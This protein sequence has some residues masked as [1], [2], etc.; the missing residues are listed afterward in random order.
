MV[1]ID[2][3]LIAQIVKEVLAGMPQQEAAA[4]PAEGAEEH[5]Y[6]AE[7][8]PLY[9]KHPDNIRS[10]TGKKLSEIT[11]QAVVDGKIEAA[12]VRISPDTLA[13]HAQIAESIGRPQ[14][15]ENFRRA[16]ELIAVP[17]A[18]ILEIYNALRPFR[19][20]KTEL[21]AI[22]DEL[23]TK[24]NAVICA[25]LIREAADVYEKRNRLKAE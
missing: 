12:D 16:R 18:R 25:G 15:A 17:D 13:K 7:D 2:S 4:A 6:T 23:Q 8:Y 3:N 21:L 22:A 1:N 5:K 20:T 11:L 10:N 9:K 19:S 14:L 24:Y